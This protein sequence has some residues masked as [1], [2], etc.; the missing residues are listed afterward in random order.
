MSKPNPKYEKIV[1]EYFEQIQA[2]RSG[3]D[4]SVE[5]LT[6]MWDDDGVFEF[7]GAPPLSAK[8]CGR[9][10]IKTLYKNRLHANGMEVKLDDESSKKLRCVDVTLSDVETQVTRVRAHNG[11]LVAGWSTRIGTH[12]K[13]GFNVSGSHTFS[14][15]DDKISGLKVVVSPK[16]DDAPNLKM[17]DLTVNDIGRLALAAWPVV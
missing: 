10:A 11:K 2:L 8:Y 16:A 15:K 9:T 6:G 17:D 4:D 1:K 5:K 13:L 7:C 12:Q 14:F 3:V